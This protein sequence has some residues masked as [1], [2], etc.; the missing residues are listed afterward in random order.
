VVNGLL[1]SHTFDQQI[2]WVEAAKEARVKRLVPLEWVGPAPKG[3]ID[4]KEKV[5]LPYT[6]A[7]HSY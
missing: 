2:P 6:R 5:C 3:V 1:A 4:I 7:R